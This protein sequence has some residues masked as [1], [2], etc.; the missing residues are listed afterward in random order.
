MHCSI[1]TPNVF[2]KSTILVT[3]LI[4]SLANP[5]PHN[6][7][8]SQRLYPKQTACKGTNNLPEVMSWLIPWTEITAPAMPLLFSSDTIPLMPWWTCREGN[9]LL[10][11]GPSFAQE[12]IAS[13][14]GVQSSGDNPIFP[15]TLGSPSS[16][17][18]SQSKKQKPSQSLPT[19]TP[20]GL[21]NHLLSTPVFPGSIGVLPLELGPMEACRRKA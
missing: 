20:S 21:H 5:L 10:G 11:Q 15:H 6:Q 12:D 18:Q 17:Q 8:V 16:P 1:L 9:R 4:A 7:I 2:Q 13:T 14:G 3:H 19:R